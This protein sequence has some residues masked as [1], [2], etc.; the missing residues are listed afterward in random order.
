MKPTEELISEHNAVLVALQILEKIEKGLAAGGADAPEHLNQ[1][2]DFFGGF[3]DRC[4]H[5]KEEG[6]LFPELEKC[7]VKREGGPI[8]VMLAE[9]EAGRGLVREMS[10]GLARLRRGDQNASNGIRETAIGYRDLLSAHIHK[11][12]TVLFPM[13]DRL[14]SDDTAGKVVG[15]FEEIE[16]NRVG[17]GKHEAHHD[18][19]HRL[20]DI[21]R[22]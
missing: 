17:P 18:M 1:L 3:V 15:R 16:L 20:K 13:A 7:G 12:N 19:L 2:I 22:V 10:D 9:H 5:A 8:G 6:A 21:Y 4:H 14:L 11:E